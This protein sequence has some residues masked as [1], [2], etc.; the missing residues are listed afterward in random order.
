MGSGSDTTSGQQTSPHVPPWMA[1]FL[2]NTAS[3]WETAQGNLPDISQLYNQIPELQTAQLNSGQTGDIGNIQGTGNQLQAS[4]GAFGGQQQ[5]ANQYNQFLSQTGPSAA[6]QQAEQNFTNF[7]NPVLESQAS[8]SG[9]GNSGAALEAS[10]VGAEQAAVP[11]LQQDQADKLTAANS[12]SSLGNTEFQQLQGGQQNALN[13]STI[14]QQLQQTEMQNLF[15]QQNTQ[16]QFGQ[17]VQFGPES[18]FGN[19]IGGGSSTSVNT[20]SKF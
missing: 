10:A 2:K 5:A 4:G 14:P 15:N 17:Q 16:Q 11:F 7:E 12:L 3:Q 19:A 9:L 1:P 20:P 6:T 13:A 8:L 18:L